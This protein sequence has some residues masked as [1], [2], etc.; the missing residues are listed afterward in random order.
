MV[1]AGVGGRDAGICALRR[2]GG[3]TTGGPMAPGHGPGPG[4]AVAWAWLTAGPPGSFHCDS[5]TFAE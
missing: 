3:P 1:A 4:A 5:L 2:G